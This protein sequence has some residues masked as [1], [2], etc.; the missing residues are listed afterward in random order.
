MLYLAI[1]FVPYED[2]RVACYICDG[3][4]KHSLVVCTMRM[5]RK[6]KTDD[7]IRYLTDRCIHFLLGYRMGKVTRIGEPW[8]ATSARELL[9]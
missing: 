7:N 9:E 8:A 4:I 3:Y 5:K 6:T 2:T 1:S